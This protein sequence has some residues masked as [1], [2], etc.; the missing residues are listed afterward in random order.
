MSEKVFCQNGL[1]T[2]QGE[3]IFF[4]Y[5]SHEDNIKKHAVYEMMVPERSYFSDMGILKI[6]A[7]AVSAGY[8][9]IHASGDEMMGYVDLPHE[10]SDKH[11]NAIQLSYATGHMNESTYKSIE[12]AIEMKK[13]GKQKEIKFR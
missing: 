4:E 3:V 9:I 8:I 1:V 11:Y 10:I 5:G 12:L 6:E 13:E 7:W 2:P